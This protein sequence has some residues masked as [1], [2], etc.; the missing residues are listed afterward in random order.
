MILY[1]Y[2]SLTFNSIY[3]CI[4]LYFLQV[5]WKQGHPMPPIAEAWKRYNNNN[6]SFIKEW[7]TPYN[8]R[9]KNFMYLQPERYL[10]KSPILDDT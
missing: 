2:I 4:L 3:L 7:I 6:Q 8:A 9:I 1:F 5:F 10:D